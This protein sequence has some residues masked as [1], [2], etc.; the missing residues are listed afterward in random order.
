[1]NGLFQFGIDSL[2]LI[3]DFVSPE[4]LKVQQTDQEILNEIIRANHL[5]SK[6]LLGEEHHKN[7]VESIEGQLM[8]ND[9]FRTRPSLLLAMAPCAISLFSSINQTVFGEEMHN[10]LKS[11]IE[12]GI[13]IENDE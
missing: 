9:E 12:R 8:T 11:G 13:Q 4:D 7:H 2:T 6:S 1:M 5:V 3:Q 10:K